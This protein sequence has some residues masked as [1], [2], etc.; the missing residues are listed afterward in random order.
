MPTRHPAPALG[1]ITA[2]IVAFRN[3]ESAHRGS[4]DVGWMPLIYL[5]HTG[6]RSLAIFDLSLYTILSNQDAPEGLL[7]CLLFLR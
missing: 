6:R 5:L 2:P 1:V 4:G 7:T 3:A